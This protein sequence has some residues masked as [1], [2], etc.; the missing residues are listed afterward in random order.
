MAPF[1]SLRAIASQTSAGVVMVSEGLEATPRS[2]RHWPLVMSRFHYA[3]SFA[4][5]VKLDSG[6][7]AFGL[8]GVEGEARAI[9]SKFRPGLESFRDRGI[10]LQK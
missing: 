10:L 8:G 9:A 4:G 5:D 7:Q 2:Q 1:F 6:A 3:A